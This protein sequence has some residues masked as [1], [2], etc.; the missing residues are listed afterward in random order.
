M[1]DNNSPLGVS[2][3]ELRPERLAKNES[4]DDMGWLSKNL[5]YPGYGFALLNHAE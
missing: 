1:R 4:I 5:M 2:E 3:G